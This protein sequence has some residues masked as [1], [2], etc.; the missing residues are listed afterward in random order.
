[1]K[2]AARLR[3]PELIKTLAAEAS[4]RLAA[5]AVTDEIIAKLYFKVYVVKMENLRFEPLNR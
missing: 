3:M 5:R 2:T 4:P 1:M